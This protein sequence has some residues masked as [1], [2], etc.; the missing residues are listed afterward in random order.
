MQSA[1]TPVDPPREPWWSRHIGGI[2]RAVVVVTGLAVLVG[3]LT[4]GQDGNRWGGYA[5][6]VLSGAALVTLARVPLLSLGLF[7][8]APLVAVSWDAV[9]IVN[10]SVAC[11]GAL[12][13]TMRGLPGSLVAFVLGGANLLAAGLDAG[14]L[15]PARDPAPS[16]ACA[17]AVVCAAIGAVLRDNARYFDALGAR[18]REAEINR[19]I[20]V[21]RNVAEERVRIARDLHDGVGHRIAVVSMRLGAAQ[22]HLPADAHEARTDLAAARTAVREVLDETQSILRVLRVSGDPDP[23]AALPEHGRIPELVESFRT[24]GLPLDA[25]LEGLDVVLAPEASVAAY[26]IAQEALTNAQRHGTGPVRLRTAPD[27]DA[28]RIEVVNRRL[29]EGPPSRGGGH[30]LV[31]MRERAESAGGT[32]SAR[33]DGRSFVVR[34]RLPIEETTP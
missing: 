7:A 22:V 19:D 31:S 12:L 17:A 9:P 10:W 28:L 32:L 20:A 2:G 5:G 4:A 1:P 8:L 30:G 14:T 27:G 21:A 11:F 29:I 3:A 25:R 26:R 34:A 16:I 15:L 13:H 24:A 33:V 23:A 18:A 6:A